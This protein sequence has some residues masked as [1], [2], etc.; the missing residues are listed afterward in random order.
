MHSLFLFYLYFLSLTYSLALISVFMYICAVYRQFAE[1][2]FFSLSLTQP[3]TQSQTHAHSLPLF[4]FLSPL[5][6][7]FSLSQTQYFLSLTQP[8]T[9]FDI[10]FI[11]MLL[12]IQE[13]YL[14]F[15]DEKKQG[16]YK[17]GKRKK[18]KNK[19]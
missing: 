3:L 16:S 15:E 6:L 10:H 11:P 17:G 13:E 9:H 14:A 19:K 5:T 12:F 2:L 1:S 18:Q 7:F 8:P 4:I